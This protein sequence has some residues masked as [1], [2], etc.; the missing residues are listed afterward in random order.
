[1]HG[2][3]T[4]EEGHLL[5][6]INFLVVGDAL[7]ILVAAVEVRNVR[8]G[9]PGVEDFLAEGVAVSVEVVFRHG[10]ARWRAAGWCEI[11][12]GEG[13]SVRNEA[14]FVDVL[15]GVEAIEDV[16]DEVSIR[17]M[18]LK[19]PDKAKAREDG[20][21]GLSDVKAVFQDRGELGVVVTFVL[22][23]LLASFL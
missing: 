14:P 1:M 23:V 18:G 8:E 4:A 21:E 12:V 20:L 7:I 13:E 17:G 19:V 5:H 11:F 9:E 2:A 22:D 3:T 16:L 15:G 10:T 6:H